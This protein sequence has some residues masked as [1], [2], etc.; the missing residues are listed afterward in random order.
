MK[1]LPSILSASSPLPSGGPV[2]IPCASAEPCI[3]GPASL[4]RGASRQSRTSRGNRPTSSLAISTFGPP[5]LPSPLLPL[6]GGLVLSHR[7]RLAAADAVLMVALVLALCGAAD[8]MTA[9]V[10]VQDS[11]IVGC[12]DLVMSE[13]GGEAGQ[14]VVRPRCCHFCCQSQRPGL[15]TLPSRGRLCMSA[16]G[17]QGDAAVSRAS[18]AVGNLSAR[19]DNPQRRPRGRSPRGRSP[20]GRRPP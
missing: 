18:Q 16:S 15:L 8:W 14:V 9:S 17:W 12:H 2:A 5:T 11:C 20:R 4:S 19:R 6:P 7:W 10:S 13:S 3:Q 1:R